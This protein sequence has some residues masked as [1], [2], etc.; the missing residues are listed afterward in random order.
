[1]AT[2]SNSSYVLGYSYSLND[3][4]TLIKND[5]N[6]ARYNIISLHA[7][8]MPWATAATRVTVPHRFLLIQ[9]RLEGDELWLKLERRPESKISLLLGFGRTTAKDQVWR[10]LLAIACLTLFCLGPIPQT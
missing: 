5:S 7:F 9:L 4:R 3:I 8:V 1:M 10:S 6:L 2:G